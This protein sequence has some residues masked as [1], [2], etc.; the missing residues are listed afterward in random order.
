MCNGQQ[1]LV[2]SFRDPLGKCGVLRIIKTSRCLP[3]TGMRELGEVLV[4]C[5]ELDLGEKP[6]V[7]PHQ[8]KQHP[9]GWS[10]HPGSPHFP[11][12]RV[13][14]RAGENASSAGAVPGLGTGLLWELSHCTGGC[15]QCEQVSGKPRQ[16]FLGVPRQLSSFP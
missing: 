5:S 14:G 12:P 13:G 3:G 7:T 6:T 11:Q 2:T 8:D 1:V 4:A 16:R 10:L 9:C 15:I